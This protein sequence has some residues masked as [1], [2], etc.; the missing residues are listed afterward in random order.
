MSHRPHRILRPLISSWSCQ[1]GVYG[2]HRPL[3]YYEDGTV[4]IGSYR[5]VLLAIDKHSQPS[6]TFSSTTHSSWPINFYTRTPSPCTASS[7]F[8]PAFSVPKFAIA[9]TTITLSNFEVEVEVFG[10]LLR[11]VCLVASVVI[12]TWLRVFLQARFRV[13]SK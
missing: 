11:R 8:Y 5:S 13:I 2:R 4:E 10:S 9:E 1:C 6:R 7:R 12:S 3:R